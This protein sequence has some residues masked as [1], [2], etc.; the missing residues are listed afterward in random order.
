MRTISGF[1]SYAVTRDGRVINIRT[2]KEKRQTSNKA[3]RGYL[4][5]DLYSNGLRRKIYIHRLVAEAYLENPDGKP[6][7]NHIDGNTRNNDVSNLEWCTP[8]E[9]VTHAANTLG[10]MRQYAEANSKRKK[11]VSCY[12]AKSKKLLCQYS[13]IREAQMKTGIPVSNIV[14]Q[15]KGRQSHTRGLIWMYVEPLGGDA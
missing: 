4:Y 13:S 1:P 2:K 14:A 10:T 9:N 3:G 12:D 5:V 11:P 15:L 7:V 8:K 6:Y